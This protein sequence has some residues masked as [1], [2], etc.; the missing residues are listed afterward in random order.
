[1][2]G[3]RIPFTLPYPCGSWHSSPYVQS[4]RQRPREEATSAWQGEGSESKAAPGWE[5]WTLSPVEQIACGG[6]QYT[7]DDNEV[8]IS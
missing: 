3:S 8:N 6:L 5:G 1:M 7:D 4:C 2:P